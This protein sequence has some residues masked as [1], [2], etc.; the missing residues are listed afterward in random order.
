MNVSNQQIAVKRFRKMRNSKGKRRHTSH[1]RKNMKIN[2]FDN[3]K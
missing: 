2:N 1:I 3:G